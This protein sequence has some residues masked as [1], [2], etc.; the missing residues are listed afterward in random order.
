MYMEI[1]EKIYLIQFHS[2]LW[3]NKNIH[4]NKMNSEVKKIIISIG[5]KI[6]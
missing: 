5:R 2:T 3:I 6:A 1:T 4:K